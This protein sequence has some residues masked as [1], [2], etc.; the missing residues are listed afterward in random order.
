[1]R[2]DKLAVEPSGA[3]SPDLRVDGQVGPNR[4]GDA[5]AANGILELAELDD[6]A[7]RG[8]A[9]SVEVGE[10]DMVST[11]VDSIDDGVCSALELVIEP[12][13]DKPP[14]ERLRREFAIERKV[15]DAP[16]DALTGKATVDALDD[17]VPFAQRAHDGL[18]IL[19]QAPLRRSEGFGKAKALEFL[20]AADQ[21]SASVCVRL[22]VHARPKINNPIIPCS[23]TG[24]RAIELGPAVCLDL[25]VEIAADLEVA[26]RSE[27]ERGQMRGAGS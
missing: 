3:A 20:H 15:S 21:G 12:A 1:L 27:F 26:A 7:R 8:I 11:P 5:L 23:R 16:F 13:R 9:R 19:R 24:K 2:S 25:S 10:A 4:Q 17:V 22:G 14:D 6:A 18:G